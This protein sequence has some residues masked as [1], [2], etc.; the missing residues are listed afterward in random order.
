MIKFIKILCTKFQ[1][2][3]HQKIKILNK[4]EINKFDLNLRSGGSVLLIKLLTH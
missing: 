3:E 1:L 2:N 4:L